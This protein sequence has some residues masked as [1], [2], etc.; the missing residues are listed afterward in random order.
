MASFNVETGDVQA[1]GEQ[2]EQYG[3]QLQTLLRQIDDKVNCIAEEG[4]RGNASES[5]LSTYEQIHQVTSAYA[6][7]IQALGVTIKTSATAKQEFSDEATRAAG[8][9]VQ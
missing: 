6:S 3:G 1:K 2:F 7:M 5:L 4:I 9:S 8:G